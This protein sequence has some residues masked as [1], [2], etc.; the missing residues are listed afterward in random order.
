MTTRQTLTTLALAL[1][2]AT[3]FAQT[4]PKV[5]LAVYTPKVASIDSAVQQKINTAIIE[6]IH[7]RINKPAVQKQLPINLFWVKGQLNQLC[8]TQ[9][10]D[11]SSF[12]L[13]IS[14]LHQNA[15]PDTAEY[16]QELRHEIAKLVANDK[17]SLKAKVLAAELVTEKL[18]IAVRLLNEN[19]QLVFSYNNSFNVCQNQTSVNVLSQKLKRITKTMLAEM[20]YILNEQPAEMLTVNE[21]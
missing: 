21:K 18:S 9:L 12:H 6:N 1:I 16:Y 17:N 11:S 7:K 8:S 20:P 2:T 19:G 13:L 5:N 14:V 4:N 10:I 15:K 3:L